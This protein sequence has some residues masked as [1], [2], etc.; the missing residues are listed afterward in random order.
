MNRIEQELNMLYAKEGKHSSY[1]R[2]HPLLERKMGLAPA[3]RRNQLEEARAR[4]MS[5]Q[6]DFQGRSV[7][8]IGAN[9]GYFSIAAAEAGACKVTAFE[10]NPEHA[11][12]LRL[13]MN[14][15]YPTGRV[16]VRECAYECGATSSPNTTADIGL[17]LNVLHHLGD[18]FGSATDAVFARAAM[19]TMLTCM[20]DGFEW[21]FFQIG[22]NW[23]GARNLPLFTSGTK[24]D[25]VSFLEGVSPAWTVAAAAAYDPGTNAY[26]PLMGAA[27]D[28]R[29]D[30]G[31]FA[32]RPL[33]LLRSHRAA[34]RRS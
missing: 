33:F 1:Q 31:E 3:T 17:F 13:A 21:L 19:T 30:L 34:E 10:A 6:L 24:Q 12:F 11:R 22:Y 25:V 28:R 26:V 20:A 4:W 2:L 29:D 9:T 5:R 8:D 7:C 14:L 15:L 23:K 18:D 16:D 32:N 27:L